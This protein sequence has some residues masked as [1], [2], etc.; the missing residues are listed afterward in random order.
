MSGR[1]EVYKPPAARKA[2]QAAAA[3]GTT[4]AAGCAAGSKKRVSVCIIGDNERIC[5]R[6]E[7]E[8]MV[9]KMTSTKTELICREI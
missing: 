1:G 8:T 6:L 5:G 4:G 3:A 2:A 7:Q 9:R